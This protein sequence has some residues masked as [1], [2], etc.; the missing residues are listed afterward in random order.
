MYS[1]PAARPG[2]NLPSLTLDAESAPGIA[3]FAIAEAFTGPISL[4][5]A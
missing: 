5:R 3:G 1:T 2:S 4:A